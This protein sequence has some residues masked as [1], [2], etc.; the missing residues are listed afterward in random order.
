MAPLSAQLP[1]QALEAPIPAGGDRLEQQPEE[2]RGMAAAPRPA[3][4]IPLLGKHKNDGAEHLPSVSQT[5]NTPSPTATALLHI[6][7]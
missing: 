2:H 4:Q 5:A 3:R 1:S 7:I 6:L